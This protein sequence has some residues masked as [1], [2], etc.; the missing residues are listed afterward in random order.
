VAWRNKVLAQRLGILEHELDAVREARSL[1]E[2]E[3]ST[4]G[5][6]GTAVRPI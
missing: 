2:I 5:E 3:R 1:E 6:L 4:A